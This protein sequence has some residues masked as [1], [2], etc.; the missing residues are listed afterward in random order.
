MRFIEW[1]ATPQGQ[2][3]LTTET[4]E[5]P[6]VAGV[7]LPEGLAALPDFKQSDFP[8]EQLG[9][10]QSEAQEIYDRAGWN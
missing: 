10:N 9:Q 6:M 1:L 2:Q 8:L 3:M 7:P 4:K 5:F